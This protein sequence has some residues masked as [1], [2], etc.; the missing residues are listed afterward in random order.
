MEIALI[1]SSLPK[2]VLE[3]F[4]VIHRGF[5]IPQQAFQVLCPCSWQFASKKAAV[6][7]LKPNYSVGSIS[8][9]RTTVGSRLLARGEFASLN[10]QIVSVQQ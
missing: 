6:A 5:L 4:L 9:P 7:P 10:S 3:V 8:S 2:Q 1:A